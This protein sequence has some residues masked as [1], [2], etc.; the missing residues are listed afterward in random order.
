MGNY[1]SYAIWRFNNAGCLEQEYLDSHSKEVELFIKE[2]YSEYI[3]SMED[4]NDN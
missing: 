3:K 2:R 4:K 1:D